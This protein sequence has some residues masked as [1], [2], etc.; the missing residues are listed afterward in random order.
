MKSYDK[1]GFLLRTKTQMDAPLSTWADDISV[2]RDGRR[3]V[4]L[5]MESGYYAVSFGVS[6]A[7]EGFGDAPI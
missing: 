5:G 4:V 2:N 1:L 3:P 6:D 7:G